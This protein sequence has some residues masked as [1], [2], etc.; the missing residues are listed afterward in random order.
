MQ[1]FLIIFNT[2]Y[3]PPITTQYLPTIPGIGPFTLNL[4]QL[5]KP[6][7]IQPNSI[8]ITE[9]FLGRPKDLLS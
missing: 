7:N 9:I 5:H 6:C 4:I 3:T 1:P 8:H 2:V